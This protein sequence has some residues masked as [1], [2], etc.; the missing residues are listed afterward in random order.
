MFLCLICLNDVAANSAPR[1]TINQLELYAHVTE[2][3]ILPHLHSGEC[4]VFKAMKINRKEQTKQ[5]GLILSCT[6]YAT[7]HLRV[8][9]KVI[10]SSVKVESD[11]VFIKTFST[12]CSCCSLTK[13]ELT[14]LMSF[15]SFKGRVFFLF[16]NLK[17]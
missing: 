16:H 6:L 1:A 3:T 4:I 9:L 7:V 2:A 8:D 12:G 14:E 11:S 10:D 5:E 17:L 15:L 13:P